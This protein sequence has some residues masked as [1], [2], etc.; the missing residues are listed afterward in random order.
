MFDLKFHKMIAE[1]IRFHEEVNDYSIKINT[2]NKQDAKEQL[3]N[4]QLEV[5]SKFNMT[6]QDF[7]YILLYMRR[8]NVYFAKY[9][10]S[11]AEKQMK[12]VMR[13]IPRQNFDML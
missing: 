2:T 12:Q 8:M 6:E 13:N 3:I 5:A 7:L 10:Q 9:Y 1:V 11:V 4:R